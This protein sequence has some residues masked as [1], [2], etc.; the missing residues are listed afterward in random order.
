MGATHQLRIYTRRVRRAGALACKSPS[1]DWPL[2]NIPITN[3]VGCLA[4]N[5]GVRGGACLAQ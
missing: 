3:I 4:Y 2:Q 1:A 5:R